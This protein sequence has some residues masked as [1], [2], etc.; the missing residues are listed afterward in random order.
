MCWHLEGFTT[1]Y[2]VT[3]QIWINHRPHV[4]FFYIAVAGEQYWFICLCGHIN[5]SWISLSI[6]WIPTVNMHLV[7][8]KNRTWNYVNY[9][10]QKFGM[11]YRHKTLFCGYISPSL[12]VFDYSQPS[13]GTLFF[14]ETGWSGL[15]RL[16][17]ILR[18]GRMIDCMTTGDLESLH[19][20]RNNCMTHLNKKT[21]EW[22]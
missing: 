1:V 14:L 5:H 2:H 19:A 6:L 11:N 13:I 10:S 4:W 8:T 18:H 20:I 12:H 9:S 17:R 21:L 3:H 16:C 22:V 15:I 7:L